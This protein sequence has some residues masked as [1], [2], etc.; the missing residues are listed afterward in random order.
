MHHV[1]LYLL[2]ADGS[3]DIQFFHSKK[4]GSVEAENE[5]SRGKPPGP[6][7]PESRK[8]KGSP[9]DTQGKDF[10]RFLSLFANSEETGSLLSLLEKRRRELEC[11]YI[12][13]LAELLSSNMGDIASLSVKPDKCH[14]LKSTVDQ[15]QQIKRR[16]QEKAA[17]LS[18]DDEVQKSDISSSSQGLV[19]KEA[20]GP[21][22]L[23][24]LDGFFLCCQ[25]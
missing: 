25:P 11:R 18:P 17:L 23:E 9:C 14:I 4:N 21:M 5:C 22:L 19:E 3:R 24:A 1:V 12:E 7:T 15:I 6:A 10:H 13:E 16:E 2:S 8:R 20:L